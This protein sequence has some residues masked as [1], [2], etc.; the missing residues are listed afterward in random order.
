MP[1]V[2]PQVLGVFLAKCVWG[3]FIKPPPIAVAPL[4]P[5]LHADLTTRERVALQTSPETCMTCHSMI[6][7]LGFTLENFDTLGR[8]RQSEL[9][10]PIDSSGLYLTTTGDEVRFSEGGDLARFLAG[11]PECQQAFV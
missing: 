1:R 6:N 3:W 11:S 4:A 10:R 5:A 8:F 9:G 7:A 2:F